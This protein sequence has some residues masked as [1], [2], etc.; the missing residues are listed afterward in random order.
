MTMNLH[1]HGLTV[2][3]LSP[4]LPLPARSQCRAIARRER[5]FSPLSRVSMNI[6]FYREDIRAHSGKLSKRRLR[7]ELSTL[8][9]LQF[10][11]W[12]RRLAGA[13]WRE[14][15]GETRGEKEGGTIID[16]H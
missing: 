4:L 15:R 12:L 8:N 6:T 16:R 5:V 14:R 13:I 9:L 2:F 3:L 10:V 11:R 7:P 1:A